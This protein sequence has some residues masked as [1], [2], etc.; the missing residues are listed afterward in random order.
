M[1]VPHIIPGQ[2]FTDHRGKLRYNNDYDLSQ[3]RRI[4][5]IENINTDLNRGW[6]AHKIEQRWFSAIS[7][8]FI[9]SVVPFDSFE[10]YDREGKTPSVLEFELNSEHLD[11]LHC[12]AGYATAIQAQ[13]DHAQIL[14]MGDYLL[15]S[16]EDDYR[17]DIDYFKK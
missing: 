1:T 13:E 12:P 2:L 8:S 11:V 14:V 3:V 5:V 4:Y 9:V 17:F 7:G 10:T 15:G 16:T 6:K